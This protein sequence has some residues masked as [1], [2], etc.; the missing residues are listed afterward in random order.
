LTDNDPGFEL[1]A[2]EESPAGEPVPADPS[3]AE[4]VSALLEDGRTYLEAELQFQKSR[5]AFVLDRGKAGAAYG[6]AAAG[7]V[8]LALVALVVGAVL[9]LETLVG[10]LAATGIVVAVLAVIAIILALAA[11]KRF[12][13]TSSAFGETRP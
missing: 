10:P 7:L 3:L 8:H 12:A 9:S 5:A 2:G 11:R 4:D 13:R 6:V 1:P